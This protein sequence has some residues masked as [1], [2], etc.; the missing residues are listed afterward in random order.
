MTPYVKTGGLG[1]VSAALPEAL[2]KIGV[3][4][5]VLLPGYL[6]LS[7]LKSRSVATLD[8]IPGLPSVKLSEAT[9]ANGLHVFIIDYPKLY[10]RDGGPYQD[11]SC[12]DWPDNVIR[13]GLLSKVAAILGS[14]SSPISW[15]PQIVHC[16][17]WQT[18][19]APAYLNFEIGRAHV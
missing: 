6:E 17:D 14:D 7:Q 4:V 3:D 13:F 2:A 16:N 5:H 10:Q 1:D 12:T 18:G 8:N 9:L 15:R 11:F 19:L